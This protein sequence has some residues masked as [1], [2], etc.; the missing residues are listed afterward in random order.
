MAF[1]IRQVCTTLSHCRHKIFDFYRIYYIRHTDVEQ[2][3]KVPCG[4]AASAINFE[5]NTSLQTSKI[6]QF[7]L[8]FLGLIWLKMVVK[9]R[10][11]SNYVYWP[12]VKGN[13]I[14]QDVE[15]PQSVWELVINWLRFQP[16]NKSETS[17]YERKCRWTQLRWQLIICGLDK[18][19]TNRN[20]IRIR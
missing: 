3:G 8:M 5:I 4:V 1:I 16:I 7:I 17:V 10:C 6:N 2:F 14:I 12:Q 15:C 11:G 9:V 13:D 20:L 18:V 19:W